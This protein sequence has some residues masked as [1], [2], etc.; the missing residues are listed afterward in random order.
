[1][2]MLNVLTIS[3]FH[4]FQTGIS[5]RTVQVIRKII[6]GLSKR[7]DVKLYS[8][9]ALFSHERIVNYYIKYSNP[10][11]L[12]Y[13]GHG[14]PDKFYGFFN[15]TVMD[16]TAGPFLKKCIIFSMACDASLELGEK[17]VKSGAAAFIGD[18]DT[19]Y[20]ALNMPEHHYGTDFTNIWKN[21]VLNLLNGV[22]V[23]STVNFAKRQWN[24]AALS[25]RNHIPEWN[26]AEKY[27]ELAEKN[28]LAHSF[29]G[30]PYAKLPFSILW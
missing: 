22:N 20:A 24:A 17:L 5:Y 3:P 18:S 7:A 21:E 30:N 19:V 6:N 13:F 29:H 2:N 9:P 25:Y 12:I 4:D 8:V 23:Q 27:A 10:D 16:E 14:D 11:L 28:A 15:M 1:M 26:H